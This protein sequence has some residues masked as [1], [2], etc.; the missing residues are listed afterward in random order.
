M[1]Y[2]CAKQLCYVMCNL[3]YYMLSVFKGNLS[4]SSAVEFSDK[5]KDFQTSDYQE[6]Y[7]VSLNPIKLHLMNS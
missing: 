2:F 3:L 4:M 1:K 7:E 5:M 6:Q